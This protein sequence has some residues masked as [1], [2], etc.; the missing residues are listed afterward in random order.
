MGGL[1]AAR[2]VKREIDSATA[3]DKR[4]WR[5]GPSQPAQLAGETA[6]ERLI[7]A[8]AAAAAQE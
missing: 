7:E 1:P 6:I 8:I 4:I 3:T 5:E 2:P